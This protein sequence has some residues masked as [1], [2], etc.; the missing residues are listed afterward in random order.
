MTDTIQP[1]APKR[2]LNIA[3][4]LAQVLIALGF[5]W[6]GWMKLT[7]PIPELA[8]MW[9]WTGDL[10]AAAVMLLGVIDI[11][12][13][14]GVLLPALTR[15]MPQLTVLAALGGVL[16]QISAAL[17][18]ASRGEMSEIVVNMIF[19][20]LCAFIAWGRWKLVPILARTAR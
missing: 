15:I 20:S 17:F 9:P 6:G 13:G 2:F 16:L 8:L 19:L 11:A 5:C 14:L 18:H 7:T 1:A 10:P 4:W 12:G 3:L